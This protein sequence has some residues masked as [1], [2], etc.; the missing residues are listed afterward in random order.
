MYCICT[1]CLCKKNE[2]QCSSGN[3]SICTLCIS[4]I[5]LSNS[6]GNEEENHTKRCVLNFLMILNLDR[7]YTTA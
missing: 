4:V 1:L 3:C 5:G 2:E 7:D 6:T